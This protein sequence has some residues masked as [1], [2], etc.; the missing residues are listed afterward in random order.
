MVTL[1]SAGLHE[2]ISICGFVF[3]NL[4]RWSCIDNHE[5]SDKEALSITR[6]HCNLHRVNS[7]ADDDS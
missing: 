7:S 2:L 6:G 1:F 5:M 4:I 3:A